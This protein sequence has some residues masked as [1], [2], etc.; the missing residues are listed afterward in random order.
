MFRGLNTA[1]SSEG[2]ESGGF[3]TQGVWERGVGNELSERYR[4]TF[5]RSTAAVF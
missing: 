5:Y 1:A 2:K 4:K 3:G